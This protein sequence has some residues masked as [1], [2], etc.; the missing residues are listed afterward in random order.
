MKMVL[1]GLVVLVLGDSHMAARDYLLTNLHDALAAEGGSIHS[2]GMCGAAAGDWLYS[3]TVSCGR[4][5]R[6]EKTQ[7][8]F[9]SKSGPT[10][11]INDLIHKHRPNLVVVE[12]ADAMAAYG[13]AELPRGWIYDQVRAL[14]GR[15]G[16][17][18]IPCIWVGPIW[19]NEGP[20]YHKTVTRVRELSQFLA[21]SVWPCTYIDSTTFARPG[22]WPTTDG[23][24]LTPAGYRLWGKGIAETIV[25]GRSQK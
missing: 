8:L 3:A 17:Q 20:P 15:I 22:E 16:A 9:S 7:P 24:H 4:G 6:H 11:N 5:E 1:A 12:S 2:Y 13:A 10:W 23:Q 19:G 25:R 14:T 21:Q 18:N